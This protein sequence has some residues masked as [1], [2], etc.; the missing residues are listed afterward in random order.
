MRDSSNSAPGVSEVTSELAD[1]AVRLLHTARSGVLCT[2]SV[3]HGGWPFGSVT[4]YA[5]SRDGS[6]VLV[7]S[8]L[9]EHTQ[10]LRADPRASLLVQ[11]PEFVQR[12]Q[13]GARVTVLGRVSMLD[14]DAREDARARYIARF[15]EGDEFLR[16]LDFR[17]YSLSVEWVRVIAGFGRV[18]WLQGSALVTNAKCDPLAGE[19]EEIL[20]HM[21]N[22]GREVLALCCAAFRGRTGVRARA[23]GVDSWGFDVIDDSSGERF[24]FDF[25]QRATSPDAVRALLATMAR[26]AR[27]RLE[28]DR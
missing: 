16:K 12:P 6:L 23:T 9:A 25:P 7:L 28:T 21:N 19:T 27:M 3:A 15:P 11:D 17:V 13:A 14:G 10:N 2:L 18:G 5:V 22:D 8:D 24:R 26:E 1:V 4:P 20:S